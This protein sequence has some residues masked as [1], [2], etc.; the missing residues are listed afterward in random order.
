MKES[1]CKKGAEGFF[2]SDSQH[3]HISCTLAWQLLECLML[4]QHNCSILSLKHPKEYAED[5]FFFFFADSN[6][7]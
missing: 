4:I 1:C 3:M 6:G 7:K 2:Q 5:L